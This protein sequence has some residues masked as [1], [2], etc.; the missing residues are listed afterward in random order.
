MSIESRIN[1]IMNGATHLHVE[2][3]DDE[4]CAGD[5]GIWDGKAL[6]FYNERSQMSFTLYLTDDTGARL[7]NEVSITVDTTQIESS[8]EYVMNY[9]NPGDIGV[10]YNDDGTINVY[11]YTDFECEDEQYYC[12][13]ELGRYVIKSREKLVV[14]KN[15]PNDTYPIKYSVSY[16]KDG[17]QYSIMSVTPSGTVNELHFNEYCTLEGNVFTITVGDPPSIDVSNI[18]IIS[19]DGQEKQITE[20][21]LVLNDAGDRVATLEFDIAPDYVTVC[22]MICTNSL[23][24]EFVEEYG[25]SIYTPYET[26]VYP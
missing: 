5:H 24:A 11:V 21:D 20:S 26:N 3:P 7:S 14:F 15:L 12:Q 18:K 4:S 23:G 22:V 19:S 1:A 17:V 8:P 13:V 6:V 10:T 25:G 2:S 9:R 16:T